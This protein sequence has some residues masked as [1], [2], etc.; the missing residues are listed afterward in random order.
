MEKTTM[1]RDRAA[2]RIERV[3][4][5]A[6]ER[7]DSATVEALNILLK[8]PAVVDGYD[9]TF[10]RDSY[11]LLRDAVIAHLGDFVHE[12]DVAEE[13]IMIK[14]IEKAGAK[15]AALPATAEGRSVQ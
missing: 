1:T 8:H 11:V 14:A 10:W 2:G 7:G 15:L 5:E 4:D 13:A 6:G 3:R 12:D 9:A